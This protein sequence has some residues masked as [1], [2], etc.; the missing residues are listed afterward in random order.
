MQAKRPAIG[1][2]VC[3]IIWWEG[4][5]QGVGE[6]LPQSMEEQLVDL[7]FLTDSH[8]HLLC[9]AKEEPVPRAEEVK[10]RPAHHIVVVDAPTAAVAVEWSLVSIG[11]GG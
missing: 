8:I 6:E 11:G 7:I 4:G 1:K 5:L 10:E 2:C 9:P 3:A